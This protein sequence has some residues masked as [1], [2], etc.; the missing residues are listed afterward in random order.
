MSDFKVALLGAI[1]GGAISTGAVLMQANMTRTKDL[2][3]EKRQKLELVLETAIKLNHCS[4]Q[5]LRDVVLENE[6]QKDDANFY[7]L[8]LSDL[9]FP[10]IDA[11]VGTYLNSLH[12]VELSVAKCPSAGITPKE[13]IKRIE[14]M[15]AISKQSTVGTELQV[16]A[17]KAKILSK[18]LQ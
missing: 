17:D 10:E 16:L 15:Q 14:C 1:V 12:A 4:L 18:T 13:K 5:R 8:A 2:A 9:Y 3:T 6:C 7:L 11:E